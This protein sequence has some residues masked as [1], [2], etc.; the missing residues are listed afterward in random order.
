[1]QML[2]DRGTVLSLYSNCNTIAT[3]EVFC[4]PNYH[5]IA[6]T[7]LYYSFQL[8]DNRCHNTIFV[9]SNNHAIAGTVLFLSATRRSMPRCYLF[10][11]QLPHNRGHSATFYLFPPTIRSRELCSF[12]Y[13][14][15]QLPCNRGHDPTFFHFQQP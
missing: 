11:F 3:M 5:A 7:V 9:I 14:P 10:L 2:S 12:F 15:L 4:H 8:Q 6:V 1:M 13:F